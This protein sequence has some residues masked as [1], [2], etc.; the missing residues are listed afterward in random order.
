MISKI[1][2][3]VSV[4]GLSACSAIAGGSAGPAPPPPTPDQYQIDTGRHVA[5]S[6]CSRCHA[7][8]NLGHSP[9]PDAPP[10]RQMLERYDADMLAKDLIDGIRVGHD[11]MPE[12]ILQVT[13]ADALVAYL[14]S[15]Q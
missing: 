4:L 13:E 10:M 12:F 11:G 1:A 15:L 8:D 2:T 6:R 14:K 3:L 7:L 9:L 5:L